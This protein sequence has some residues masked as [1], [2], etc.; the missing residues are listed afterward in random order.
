MFELSIQKPTECLGVKRMKES[1]LR[2][3]IGKK[4]LTAIG[5]MLLFIIRWVQALIKVIVSMIV[6]IADLWPLDFRIKFIRN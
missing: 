5:K 2:F 1:T 6:R 4:K 3:F